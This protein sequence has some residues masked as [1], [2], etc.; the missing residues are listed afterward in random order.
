MVSDA[1]QICE[2][3]GDSP[4]SAFV[5]LKRSLAASGQDDGPLYRSE[6]GSMAMRTEDVPS[7]YMRV[8]ERSIREHAPEE[9]VALWCSFGGDLHVF[10]A[11]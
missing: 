9:G 8:A 2:Q 10:G 1:F 3:E 7:D 5:E 11:R 6:L 4:L